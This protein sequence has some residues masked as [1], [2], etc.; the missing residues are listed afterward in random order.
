MK[1]WKPKKGDTVFYTEDHGRYSAESV[2]VSVGNKWITL[3]SG[4]KFDSELL[5][6][7][8]GGYS[9][10]PSKEAY[11][12]EQERQKLYRKIFK[13]LDSFSCRKTVSMEQLLRIEE[14]LNENDAED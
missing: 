2:V 5:R 11:Q 7:E 12:S 6:T 8:T 1:N 3:K 13:R 9:L 4:T 14:I 10:Y